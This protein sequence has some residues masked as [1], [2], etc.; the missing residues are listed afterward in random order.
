MIRQLVCGIGFIALLAVAGTVVEAGKFNK[1]LK[2]GDAA[3]DWSRLAGTDDKEHALG[4][5][6]SKLMVLVYTC[7]RC[8][9][10]QSYEERLV[11]FAADYRDQGVAVVAINV[12]GGKAES[13]AMMKSRA[14]EQSFGFDYL[15]DS[16]QESAKAYG[17]RTTPT[18]FLLDQDRKVIYMGAFDD[19]WQAEAAVEHHYL[20]DAVSAALA[21]KKIEVAETLSAGCGIPYHGE[22]E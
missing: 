20:I 6:K 22:E 15:K 19:N 5:Y 9:V 8:P 3:P 2:I 13:L 12:N 21:G 10:A 4:D 1:K 18:V 14:T 16:S 11:K 7:N 17:A